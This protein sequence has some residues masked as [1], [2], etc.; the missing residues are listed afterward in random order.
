MIMQMFKG[1]VPL[2]ICSEQVEVFAFATSL[3]L[4]CIKGGLME[5]WFNIEQ[6]RPGF[7]AVDSTCGLEL[8]I[9]QQS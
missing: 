6:M 9:L 3:T 2:N 5:I 4:Q 1:S 8:R 7:K